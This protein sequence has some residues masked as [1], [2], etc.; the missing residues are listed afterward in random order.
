MLG[1]GGYNPWTLARYWTGIWARLSG[2]EAPA[3]LNGQASA[4]LRNL[5]CD[6]IDDDEIEPAWLTT[7]ADV[8]THEP[9]RTAVIA[10]R[11]RVMSRLRAAA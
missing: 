11:D 5:A 1:G 4:L 7:L 10:L 3:S 8:R 6:L 2:R 9:V